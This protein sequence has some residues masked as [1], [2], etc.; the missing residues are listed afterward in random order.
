MAKKPEKTNVMRLLTQA[1]IPYTP[2][3]YPHGDVSVDGA[4]VAAILNEPPEKV[5]KT[6]VTRGAKKGSY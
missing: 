3:Y 2:H 5:F 1:K 6:L 4:T